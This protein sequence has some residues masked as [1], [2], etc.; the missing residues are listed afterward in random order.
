MLGL[1]PLVIKEITIKK[2]CSLIFEAQCLIKSIPKG[3]YKI[4]LDERG[5]NLDSLEFANLIALLRDQGTNDLSFIIG[6]ADGLHD[7]IKNDAEY[8]LSFGKLVWPHLLMRLLLCEQLY[9]A[10]SILGSKPY[11]RT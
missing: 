9:R 7:K 6:S 4:A 11:H 5:K 3:S 2:K 10:T 8:L 1:G